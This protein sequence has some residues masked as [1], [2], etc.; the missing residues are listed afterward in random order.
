[1]EASEIFKR[2]RASE[3][4]L[5][6]LSLVKQADLL[7]PFAHRAPAH[8]SSRH[9]LEE[10]DQGDYFVQLPARPWSV[11]GTD[12]I[13]PEMMANLFLKRSILSRAMEEGSTQTDQMS[14]CMSID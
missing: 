11:A 14:D 8:P 4:P 7:L 1:M 13:V 6:V 12:R 3:D 5:E 2:V 9:Q 10:A